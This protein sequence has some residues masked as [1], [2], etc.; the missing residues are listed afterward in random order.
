MDWATAELP[1]RDQF[2][3]WRHALDDTHL[4]WSLASSRSKSYA[5]RLRVLEAGGMKV[6]DC[7]CD[8]CSG[9]R[10]R[11]DITRGDDAYYGVLMVRKGRERVA[12]AGRTYELSPGA[13]LIWD[14]SRPISFDV[15]DPLEKCTLMVSREELRQATGWAALPT[16]LID[17]GQGFG[18]LLHARANA[19]APIM[20]DF[21]SGGA[22]AQLVQGL[23]ND[24]VHALVPAARIQAAPPRQRLVRRIHQII[25]LNF[26][27]P[28]LDPGAVAR[29]A[30]ISVRY[31]HQVLESVAETAGARILRRRL[32][33]LRQGL[34]DPALGGASITQIGFAAGFSSAAHISRAFRDRYGTSPSAYRRSALAAPG[35]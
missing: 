5:A 27:D 32:E 13:T 35:S 9:H 7:I 14:A 15:V 33:A 11:R 20:Q 8:P 31:L 26:T 2:E 1:V 22:T 4:P 18:A 28:E 25:D 17:S 6:V 19:L 29:T 24:L 21:G 23:L 30:G 10:D 12:Q 34:A 16:G 3:A